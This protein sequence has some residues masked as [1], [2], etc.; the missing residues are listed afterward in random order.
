MKEKHITVGVAGHVDHGK[1]ALVHCLT[2]I[3]TDRLKEEKQRGVSIEPGIA[4]LSL[5]SGHSIALVDCPG[6]SDYL[7][8]TIRGLSSVDMAILVVAAD[9]GVMPQTLDHLEVL[10]VLKAESGFVV[11][12]KTDLV[13]EE[14]IELADLEIRETVQGTF[15]ENKPIIPFS[16]L[17]Q[18]GLPEILSTLEKLRKKVQGKSTQSPFRLWIDQA[19]HFPGFGTVVSGTVQSGFIKQDDMVQI[20]PSRKETKVRFL[21]VH[22]QKVDEAIAGQRA[23]IN[24]HKVSLEE[25]G[26]GMMLAAPETVRPTHLLNAELTLLSK[27]SSPLWN[28]QRIKLYIGTGLFQAMVVMMKGQRLEP[29]QT[30]LVQFRLQ[31]P[32]ALLPKDPFVIS[33]MNRNSVIGGG[34]ILEITREK[35]RTVKAKKT[36]DYLEPLF[37]GDLKTLIQRYCERFPNRTLSPE[38]L[39]SDTGFFKE[40]IL[41]T[42]A[43]RVKD[44][45]LIDLGGGFFFPKG[46]FEILKK[47]LLEDAVNLLSRDVFRLSV[48]PEELRHLLDPSMEEV[49][50]ASLLQS[51][52]KAG[53]LIKV[54]GLYRIPDWG[55]RLSPKQEKLTDRLLDHAR[56]LGYESFS[57]GYFCK[58]YKDGFAQKEVQKLLDHLHAQKKLIRLNDNRF[59]TPEALEDLERKVE[60]VIWTKGS[61]GLGDI[62]EVFGYGRTRGIP[63]LEHLDTIGFT[64]RV[65]DKRILAGKIGA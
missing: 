42:L 26:L 34:S 32:V 27:T 3:N 28:R 55:G 49:L 59:L 12:N 7:K 65:G 38:A 23:G 16:A 61:L 60:E 21:E 50:F 40:S 13:D 22:H 17:D 47:K 20:L 51:V 14:T 6:H 62:K 41:K 56:Q 19:R 44:G 35:F 4:L 36:V 25:I 8:N 15:L 2:G 18:R 33:P 9:D 39:A 58:L 54:D 46:R 45:T 37:Q 5:P 30:G 24:L 53:R 64:Y 48:G 11:L 43:D 63:V 31:E 52:L 10:K 57:A 1:T 29:G